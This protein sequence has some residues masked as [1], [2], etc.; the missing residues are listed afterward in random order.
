MGGRNGVTSLSGA[1]SPRGERY[2]SGELA[3][4]VSSAAQIEAQASSPLGVAASN[5]FRCSLDQVFHLL[6]HQDNEEE[7]DKCNCQIGIA[8]VF[9]T[10]SIG[11][12]MILE[13]CDAKEAIQRGVQAR[14]SKAGRPSGDGEAAGGRGAGDSREPAADLSAAIRGRQ[15]GGEPGDGAEVC[16]AVGE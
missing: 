6:R 13:V 9:R 8:P 3:K 4:T 5:G 11:G 10:L 14:G 1:H 2:I 16:A 15:M 7:F 12:M